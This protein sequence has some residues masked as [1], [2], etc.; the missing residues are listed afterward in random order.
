L[1]LTVG[2]I[3]KVLLRL[4]RKMEETRIEVASHT[5][6]L[7][8]ILHQNKVVSTSTETPVELRMP[9]KNASDVE[10]VERLLQENHNAVFDRL[11]RKQQSL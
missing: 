5:S 10:S 4:V 3:T 7:K 6:M 8:A 9:L 11:V 2:F 1:Y